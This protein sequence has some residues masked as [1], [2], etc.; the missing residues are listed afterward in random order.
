MYLWSS[1]TWYHLSKPQYNIPSKIL[2][3]LQPLFFSISPVFH[4]LIY[5]CVCV[6]FGVHK[7]SR[8]YLC[9]HH[10]IQDTEPSHYIIDTSCSPHC[11]SFLSPSNSNHILLTTNNLFFISKILKI[12]RMLY[13]WNYIVCNILVLAFFSQQNSLEFI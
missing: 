5:M 2:I 3:L 4:I 8:F 12:S 10:H 11:L 7:F 13:K 9:I 6:Y 1:F